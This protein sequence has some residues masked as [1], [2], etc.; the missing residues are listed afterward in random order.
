MRPRPT[1]QRTV[2]WVG[3]RYN[4]MFFPYTF[5]YYTALLTVFFP[6]FEWQSVATETFVDDDV[7]SKPYGDYYSRDPDA[8]SKAFEPVVF[9]QVR[10]RLDE[11]SSRPA[12]K[13]SKNVT[14]TRAAETG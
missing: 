6:P 3:P 5:V 14:T 13:V 10:R 4:F 12:T 7:A 1:R 8:L 2:C 11:A 9:E